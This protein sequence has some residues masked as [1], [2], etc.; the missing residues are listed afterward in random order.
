MADIWRC[1]CQDHGVVPATAMQP[2]PSP[3]AWVGWG[4]L[5]S[6]HSVVSLRQG[7]RGQEQAPHLPLALCRRQA[8]PS[9]RKGRLFT[10]AE[11]VGRGERTLSALA[12]GEQ[13]GSQV[14][15]RL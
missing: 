11:G 7:G 5:G 12:D 13:A 3:L 10:R 6:R 1:Y 4:W 8:S 2:P 14:G 9:Q 15:W